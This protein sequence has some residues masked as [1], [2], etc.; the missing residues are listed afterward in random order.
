MKNSKI[1]EKYRSR[2]NNDKDKGAPGNVTR[3]I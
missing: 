2:G 3:K 1:E